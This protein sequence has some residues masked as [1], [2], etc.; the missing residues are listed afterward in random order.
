MM[1]RVHRLLPLLLLVGC[2]AAPPAARRPP[3]VLLYAPATDPALTPVACHR[4]RRGYGSGPVC[5]AQVTP[6]SDVRLEGGRRVSLGTFRSLTCGGPALPAFEAEGAT[7]DAFALWPPDGPPLKRP[8]HEPDGGY[9]PAIDRLTGGERGR[10][11]GTVRVDLDGDRLLERIYQVFLEESRRSGLALTNGKRPHEARWLLLRD[12]DYPY[13][14]EAVVDL[15]RDG[16]AEV[17]AVQR[18]GMGVDMHVIDVRATDP[19]VA[20]WRCEYR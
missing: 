20:S 2:G 5:A 8:D 14:I 16:V 10:I 7:A 4:P 15:D 6:G 1:A 11:V 3:V 17:L 12:T 19:V 13:A 9:S 18:W